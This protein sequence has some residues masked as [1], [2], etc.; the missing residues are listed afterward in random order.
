[1]YGREQRGCWRRWGSRQEHTVTAR[2]S[3]WCYRTLLNSLSRGTLSIL[4][5]FCLSLSLS[6]FFFCCFFLF[7]YWNRDGHPSNP[8]D[9]FLTDGASVGVQRL[10]RLLIRDERDGVCSSPPSLPILAS[11][12]PPF[13]LFLFTY[14]LDFDSN[15]S[16]PPVLS[17]D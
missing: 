17:H 5:L 10:L 16:I 7:I 15:T 3:L 12:P 11:S 9:I 4:S 13:F 8:D 6:F 1:M 14:I 2:A